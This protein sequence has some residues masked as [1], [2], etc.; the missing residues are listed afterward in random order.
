M[1]CGHHGNDVKVT[2]EDD[3]RSNNTIKDNKI[4][5]ERIWTGSVTSKIETLLFDTD[6]DCQLHDELT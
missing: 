5:K 1:K 4:E 3:F 6:T 2:D